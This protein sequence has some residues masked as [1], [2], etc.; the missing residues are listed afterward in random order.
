VRELSPIQDFRSSLQLKKLLKELNPDLIHLHSSKAGVLGRLA[1]SLLFSN[2][3]QIFYTPHGYSFLRLD[4]S[5][6]K[7]KL[8]PCRQ[9]CF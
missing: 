6:T 1:N 7:R 2:K 3:K 9:N 8:Y 5:A 4:V